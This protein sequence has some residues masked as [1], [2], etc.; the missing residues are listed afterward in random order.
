MG[1]LLSQPVLS[2]AEGKYDT[3]HPYEG[4]IGIKHNSVSRQSNSDKIA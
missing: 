4:K 1:V 3:A 2:E